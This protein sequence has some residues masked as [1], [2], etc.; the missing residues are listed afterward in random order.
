[1]TLAA[2]LTTTPIWPT[3]SELVL[4]VICFVVV[5][6]VLGKLLLPRI[7]TGKLDRVRLYESPDLFVDCTAG[8]SNHNG[9][10]A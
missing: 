5:F 6:G 2:S 9:E 7:T 3:S 4:G 10:R 1:M 8:H